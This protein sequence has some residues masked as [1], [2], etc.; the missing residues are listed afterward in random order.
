[1]ETDKSSIAKQ[2]RRTP[3]SGAGEKKTRKTAAN[4]RY[5]EAQRKAKEQKDSH[6][7]GVDKNLHRRFAVSI[8]PLDLHDRAPYIEQQEGEDPVINGPQDPE[9]LEVVH[10]ACQEGLPKRVDDFDDCQ[11]CETGS[12]QEYNHCFGKYLEVQKC[13]QGCRVG[14]P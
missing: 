10:R 12:E 2:E 7:R 13:R 14:C 5:R 3:V 1:M 6:L 4:F 8:V 9:Q 11:H